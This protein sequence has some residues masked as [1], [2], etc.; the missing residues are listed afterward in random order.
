MCEFTEQLEGCSFSELS[1][2]EKQQ[3]VWWCESHDWGDIVYFCG[4]GDTIL[5][6]TKFYG[7]TNR[8]K[9]F[10]ELLAWAGY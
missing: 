8:F 7:K 4:E 6:V 2:C 5:K 9:T 3:I 1:A 10:D